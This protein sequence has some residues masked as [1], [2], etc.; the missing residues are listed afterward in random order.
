MYLHL[1]PKILLYFLFVKY[2]SCTL[3]LFIYL[4]WSYI[5]PGHHSPLSLTL[6]NNNK[7]II[8]P[9]K[10]LFMFPN[11]VKRLIGLNLSLS[12]LGMAI[13]F[14]EGSIEHNNTIYNET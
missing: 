3:D 6:N 4:F 8:I 5:Y 2:T 10:I 7:I 11:L 9:H 14:I 12:L 1:Y 13:Y